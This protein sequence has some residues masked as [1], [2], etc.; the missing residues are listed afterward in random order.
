MGPTRIAAVALLVMSGLIAAP[1]A[2]ARGPFYIGGSVGRSDI[3]N[4]IAIPGLITSGTVDG[5]DTGFKIFGGYEFNP[6]L[7]VEI[8]LVNL[9]KAH[10][11]GMHG[12]TTVAGGQVRVYGFNASAVGILPVNPSFSLFGKIGG[13]VWEAK[14]SDTTGRYPVYASS[15]DFFFGLGSTANFTKYFSA[16]VEWERFNAGGGSDFYTGAP[17]LTGSANID[18]VSLGVLFKF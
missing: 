1:E 6:Y 4:D 8:A 17:S 2:S 7:A 13:F 18:F 3:E 5:G 14:Q 11:S 9:G 16:R 15:A 10:Y 12:S